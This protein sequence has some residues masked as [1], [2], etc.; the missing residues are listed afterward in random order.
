M[1]KIG[2]L[3][4][5]MALAFLFVGAAHAEMYVEGYIGGN[6]TSSIGQT[7][8]VHDVQAGTTPGGGANGLS[9]YHLKYDGAVEPTV[10]GGVKVGTWFVKEGFAGWSG[11]PDWAKYLGFYTD[12][13]Y[14][15]IYTR[16]NRVSGT[17]FFASN[18]PVG[19][20]SA[21]IGDAGYMKTEGMAATWAFML[22]ARYGF[23]PD[24][25][26]PFGRLQPYVAAGPAVMFSSMKPKIWTQRNNPSAAFPNT[27]LV[28][29]PGTQGS[30]DIALA[31]D[32]GVRYMALKNV[33]LDISFKYRYANPHYNFSGQ[34]GSLLV[35]AHFSLNPTL[36]LYSFQAGVAYHF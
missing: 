27:D 8:N 1:K 10:I 33:S 14:H 31:V 13:S 25:E 18:F 24:S 3:A 23:L 15:R 29:S 19:G 9:R 16:D 4:V 36:N 6:L 32:A 17:D 5:V 2:I 35:P 22:A 21:A 20:G 7:V 12:F 34:D 30:T 26:V 28:M 11:Y